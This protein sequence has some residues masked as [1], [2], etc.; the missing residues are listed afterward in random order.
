VDS[1]SLG[2][3]THQAETGEA[4]AEQGQRAGFRNP[5]V[6]ECVEIVEIRRE[7]IVA[8]VPIPQNDPVDDEIALANAEGERQDVP[9]VAGADGV[10]ALG[11]GVV[12]DIRQALRALAFVRGAEIPSEASG[13][14]SESLPP[15]LLFRWRKNSW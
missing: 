14:H 15:L 7:R 1:G 12:P 13:I 8:V 2:A 11:L 5:R 6:R 4:E 10:S 3:P 9:H